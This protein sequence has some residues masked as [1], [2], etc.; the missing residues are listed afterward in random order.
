VISKIAT[1]SFFAVAIKQNAIADLST[2]YSGVVALSKKSELAKFADFTFDMMEEIA[3]IDQ[4]K[5]HFNVIFYQ[6]I[7]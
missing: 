6:S 4:S 3:L 7:F 1:E 2:I 5:R